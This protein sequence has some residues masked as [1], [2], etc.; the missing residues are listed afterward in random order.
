MSDIVNK[1]KSFIVAFLLLVIQSASGQWERT[2]FPTSFINRPRLLFQFEKGLYVANSRSL[3]KSADNG[4]NWSLV[5]DFN[6]SGFSDMEEIG[7]A[8]IATANVN[9]EWPDTTATVFKS[10]DGGQTW[11]SLFCSI[12]GGESIEKLNSKLF[13]DSDGDLYCSPDTGET[14]TK[15]NTSNYFTGKIWDVI[16]SENSLYVRLK[17]EQLYRSVDE[18]LS[19]TQILSV[20]FDDHFYHVVTKDSTIFVGTSK[21]GC[22][23]STNNGLSWNRVNSG[24]PESSGF[25]DLIFCEDFIVGAVSFDFYQTV[26]IMNCSDSIWYNFN[27]GLDLAPAVYI[28]D[29][30]YNSDYLF[31]A[32]DIGLWRRPISELVTSVDNNDVAIIPEEF[33][34][35]S[36]PNPFNSSTTI[37]FNVTSGSHIQLKIYDIWGREL[38]TL[39]DGNLDCGDQYFTWNA[40][41]APSG[42]YFVRLSSDNHFET[43]KIILMK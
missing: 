16:T 22:L 37:R 13:I 30:E 23:K 8:F 2:N 38:K 26:Y 3:Y 19:W 41:E 24:L 28:T 43:T 32:S 21:A 14:W 10:I 40:S 15:I 7:N 39:F 11:D 42:I 20:D 18:G 34:L 27:Y 25:L 4:L 31:M 29:F 1:I 36:F 6:F 9:R 33:N 17:T 12:H 5:S 35:A